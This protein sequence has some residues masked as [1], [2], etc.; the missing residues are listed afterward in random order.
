M[1]HPS[2]LTDEQIQMR[3]KDLPG[4]RV[5]NDA[6]CRDYRFADFSKA[7]GY[8]ASCALVAEKLNHHP[9]WSNVYGQVN[10]RLSTHDVGGI[11][12]LD[13][14]LAMACE[15]RAKALGGA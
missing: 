12:A 13:F 9:N 10:M 3:L 4:W 7:F 14:E 6:L 5:E 15:E 11:T 2:R 8:M 1:N